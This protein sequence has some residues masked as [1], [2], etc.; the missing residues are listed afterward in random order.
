MNWSATEVLLKLAF[1][2]A[3][4]PALFG[5]YRRRTD[6]ANFVKERDGQAAFDA[7]AEGIA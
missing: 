4:A 1:A 5:P 6:V 3:N 2:A 7:A